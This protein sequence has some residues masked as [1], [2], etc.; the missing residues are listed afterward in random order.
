MLLLMLF[1]CL[2]ER[3]ISAPHRGTGRARRQ[4]DLAAR[5]LPQ[6]SCARSS[7]VVGRRMEL[8]MAG[9]LYFY[10][11]GKCSSTGSTPRAPLFQGTVFQG[12]LLP[13][14]RGTPAS[15]TLRPAPRRRRPRVRATL[16][17]LPGEPV[18]HRQA[19]AL[20]QAITRREKINDVPAIPCPALLFPPPPGTRPPGLWVR[21]V[22]AARE[23]RVGERE[24]ARRDAS[25]TKTQNKTCSDSEAGEVP[26]IEARTINVCRITF[27]ML[28]T[29][30]IQENWAH[31]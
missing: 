4:E 21:K 10:F 26:F 18:L 3:Q 23:S 11:R 22:S 2:C 15:S 13:L 16:L 9:P 30:N 6:S 27:P 17:P 25:G 8:S 19:L 5:S 31:Q 20:F 29:L 14:G 28:R 12:Q 7:S 24:L 1:L